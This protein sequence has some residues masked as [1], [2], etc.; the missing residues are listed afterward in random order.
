MKMSK[1]GAAVLLCLAAG[2]AGAYELQPPE[3]RTT[4]SWADAVAIGDVDGDGRDDVVLTT[5]QYFDEENDN[6]IFVYLQQRD[7]TL[8]APVKTSYSGGNETGLA[9]ADL[10]GD[11]GREILVGSRAGLTVFK[12]NRLERLRRLRTYGGATAP[13]EITDVAVLDVDRD[14]HPD[15]VG[16]TWSYGATVF[17]GDGHGGIRN[18]VLLPTPVEGYDDIKSGDLNG[19]GYPDLVVMSGQG[20]THA[21]VYYNDGT[22]DM[23]TPR[24]LD[25]NPG[26]YVF[27]SALAIGDFN[28]DGRN[29]LVAEKD[30]TSVSL[31]AQKANGT[32]G[33]AS[34]VA[35]DYSPNAALGSDMDGDGRPDLVIAHGGGT[36][37]VLYQQG[38][39]L[40][41]EALYSGMY[42]TWLNSQGL[43]VGD[44]NGDG[45]KDAAIANYNSGL[46]TYLGSSCVPRA[47]LAPGLG[48]T[49]NVVSL[50][51]DNAGDAAAND[52][53][54]AL[55]LSVTNGSLV[56]GTLPSGCSS[57]TQS[58]RTAQLDC[59]YGSLAAGASATRTLSFEATGGDLRN[60]VVARAGVSTTSPESRTDNNSASKRLMSAF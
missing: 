45:C 4:G 43:A 3:A 35:T 49:R 30:Q 42:A 34:V 10:D 51:V 9:L 20:T 25:P 14:G 22:Q 29:D 6:K 53:H 59:S 11:G 48:L 7:G 27:I 23:S 26:D 36:L 41:A 46:V 5:T 38:G 1:T 33:T 28:G 18:Q 8:A 16:Q 24:D 15:I 31:F 47:D 32:L 52:A 57:V 13:Y 19:D 2:V 44:I 37:G 12:W 55:T 60:A 54:A 50:R 58:T 56:L 40:Q 39:Q 21:Y 17:F